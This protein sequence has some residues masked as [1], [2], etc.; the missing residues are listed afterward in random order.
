M[1]T[2]LT[3]LC[4]LGLTSPVFAQ[5]VLY[6]VK[7]KEDKVPEEV[8]SAVD[9]EFKDYDVI[10]YEAIPFTLVEDKVIV[11]DN[12]DFDPSDYNTYQVTLSGKNTKMNAYYDADGNLVSTYENIKN[13]ALPNIVDRAIFK[14]YPNAKLE[15]D[16]YVSTHF[17]KD[18]KTTVYYHV[19][20]MNNGKNH[21]MYIDGNGNIIRG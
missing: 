17:T 4:F 9:K 1:K 14:K 6:S 12:K 8:I 11:T 19:K 16:R 2:F 13:V 21:H 10:D 5:D 7:V 18:G 3:G 15:S 20:I